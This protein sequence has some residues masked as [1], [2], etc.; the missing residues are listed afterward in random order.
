MCWAPG[1]NAEE[2]EEE[3]EDG[4]NNPYLLASGSMDTSVK[5]WDVSRRR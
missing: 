2:M 5:V 3:G 1:K 4:V